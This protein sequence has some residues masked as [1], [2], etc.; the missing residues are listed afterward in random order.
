MKTPP[1]RTYRTQQRRHKGKFIAMS[2]YIKSIERLQIN[3]LMLHLKLLE[4]QEQTEPK[5]SRRREMKKSGLKLMNYRPKK[6]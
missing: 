3:E 5:I 4:K 2:A 1:T 6:P